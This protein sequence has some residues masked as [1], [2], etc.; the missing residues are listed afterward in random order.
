MNTDTIGRAVAL[1]LGIVSA[2]C[3]LGILLEDVAK[4]AAS[5]ELKHALVIGIVALAILAGHSVTNAWRARSAFGVVGFTVVFLAATAL[6][7]YKSTGRQAEHTFQSQAEADFA[8]EERARIRPLLTEAEA[9]LSGAAK[10]IEK[11]CVEGKASKKQCDGLRATHGVYTAA[12]TGHKADLARLGAPKPVAP[13]AENFAA[14]AAVF[15]ADKAKVKAASILVVPFLQTGLYE[16][17]AIVGLFF[18]FRHRKAA[19]VAER[20]PVT[21]AEQSDFTT[22]DIDAARQL[23][24]GGEPGTGNWGNSG[25]GGEVFRGSTKKGGNGGGKRVYARSEALLDL[26]RRLA[27]GETVAAQDE[28]AAAWGVDK[29]TVSKWL[30]QWRGDDRIPASQRVGRCHRLAAVE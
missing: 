23:G 22:D 29:S 15:G 20:K 8:A 17:G 24:I 3:A 25:N 16:F 21:P 6:V 2:A 26:T 12:V 18:A 30:K 11:Q 10:A 9:M 5:F 1:V 4:G 28:L 19:T 14:L 13:E 27:S 7:V